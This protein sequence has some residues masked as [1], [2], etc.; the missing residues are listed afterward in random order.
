[1]IHP[2]HLIL[3]VFA[4]ALV[5]LPPIVEWRC[6][7]KPEMQRNHRRT[8]SRW[9]EWTMT[10]RPSTLWSRSFRWFFCGI[11]TMFLGITAAEAQQSEQ[12]QKQVEQLKQ[13]FENTTQEYQATTQALSLRIAALE[14]QIQTEKGAAAE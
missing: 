11:A 4:P 8:K 6:T 3:L 14:Q 1:M 12:L 13:E 2:A 10:S 7:C 5:T 9:Q